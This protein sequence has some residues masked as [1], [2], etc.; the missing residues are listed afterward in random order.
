[1]TCA[2][3][4][5]HTRPFSLD[6]AKA[7]AP[8]SLTC[9]WPVSIVKYDMRDGKSPILG[10]YGDQDQIGRWTA[11]GVFLGGGH[12]SLGLVMMPIGCLDEKPVFVGDI[13]ETNL[14]EKIP[15]TADWKEKCIDH[16]F[17]WPAPPKVY[18]VTG[19]T[20]SEAEASWHEG[21]LDSPPFSDHLGYVRMVFATAA[22]R[23]YIDNLSPLP[24]N[25]R[26]R[27]KLIE[28][29]WTAPEGDAQ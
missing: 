1:M 28:M 15:I 26:P 29:G 6:D 18:P 5:L 14:G 20:A 2:Q 24:L 3:R 19:M 8:I 23:H 13:L 16:W 25:C 7:G 10:L 22:I 21:V 27:A 4:P 17:R 9:G 11:S 12:S